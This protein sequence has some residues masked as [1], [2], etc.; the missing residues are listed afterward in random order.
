MMS[1]PEFPRCILPV[2]CI[3]ATLA[4]QDA[5][6]RDP[7]EYERWEQIKEDARRE[8][9]EYLAQMEQAEHERRQEESE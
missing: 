1:R 8:E 5:Y 7:E 4:E 3:R 6:D 9:E 2:A